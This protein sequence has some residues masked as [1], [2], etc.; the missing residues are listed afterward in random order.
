M[1]IVRDLGVLA[2][3]EAVGH[4]LDRLDL[5]IESFAHRIGD[6]MLE[7]RQNLGRT[8]VPSR[9]LAPVLNASP[10]NTRL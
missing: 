9:S 3:P 10:R 2:V 5:G 8:S 4:L 6:P 7:V 1:E